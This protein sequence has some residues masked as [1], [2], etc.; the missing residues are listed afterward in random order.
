MAGLALGGYA[1][2]PRRGSGPLAAALVRHRRGLIGVDRAPDAARVRRA[3][4]RLRPALPGGRRQRPGAGRPLRDRLRRAAGPD[5]PD[6]RQLSTDREGGASAAREDGG[7]AIGLLYA[8][9][10]LGAVVGTLAAGFYLI[11]EVGIQGRS[12]WPPRSIWLAGLAALLAGNGSHRAGQRRRAAHRRHGLRRLPTLAR[13]A[14]AVDPRSLR[15]LLAGVRGRLDPS[16]GALPGDHHLRLHRDAGGVPA[17]HHP[18]QRRR[19]PVPAS[20]PQRAARAGRAPGA[21]RDQL[22]AGPPG[23]RA[24]GAAAGLARLRQ[25]RRARRSAQWLSWRSRRCSRPPSSSA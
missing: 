8:I 24:D 21:G 9:N 17:R 2:R 15:L 12:A 1:G 25:R 11:G 18:R 22:A 16:A 14:A 7:R 4:G 23:A 5:R 3:P 6:G 10:T 13:S 20:R 19:Q